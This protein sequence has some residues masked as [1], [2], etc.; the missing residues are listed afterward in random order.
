[1]IESQPKQ[2]IGFAFFLLLLVVL[3]ATAGE[4]GAQ[5]KSFL[6]RVQSDK[7]NIYILGSVHF[8]KKENYPLNKTIEK[9]FD[10]TQKLVLEI[11]LK[12][13][14]AGTIQRVAL[15]KASIVTAPSSKMFPRRPTV[16]RKSAR[17]NW[18]SISAR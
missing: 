5:D 7:G 18:V 3:F 17:K 6:W 4:A 1:M 8:L 14:D 10:S 11:D 12:S 13:E 16:S 9:A 2:I 15:K